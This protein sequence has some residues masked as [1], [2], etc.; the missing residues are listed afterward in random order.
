[1]RNHDLPVQW[2]E[3]PDEFPELLERPL[4]IDIRFASLAR[5]GPLDLFQTHKARVFPA[6]AVHVGNGDVVGHAKGP[7][8]QGAS[9]VENFEALP[10]LEVDVLPQIV[11]LFRVCFISGGQPVERA[12]KLADSG[13]V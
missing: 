12:A 6:L 10:E 2:F 7:R 13:L 4:V 1:M 11:A 9:S 8:L 3:L 5:R